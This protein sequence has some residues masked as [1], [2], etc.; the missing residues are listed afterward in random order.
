[1]ETV[2]SANNIAV[3]LASQHAANI[4]PGSI[5]AT[6]RLGATSPLPKPTSTASHQLIGGGATPSSFVSTTY[7]AQS[8]PGLAHAML[9]GNTAHYPVNSNLMIADYVTPYGSIVPSQQGSGASG[10]TRNFRS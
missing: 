7:P 8:S 9:V 10:G 1:M 6:G 2:P 5:P 3:D 4:H